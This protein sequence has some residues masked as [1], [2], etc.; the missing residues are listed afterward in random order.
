MSR[1]SA[2]ILSFAAV[3]C[4][5]GSRNALAQD[6]NCKRLPALQDSPSGYQKR[7]DRCE[8]LYVANVGSHSLAAMS[9]SLGKQTAVPFASS[10]CESVR[11][12]TSRLT[13]LRASP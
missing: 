11:A 7:G 1:H 4:F 13:F 10:A 3:L 5:N 8:G 12:L 2:V 6:A 9:F